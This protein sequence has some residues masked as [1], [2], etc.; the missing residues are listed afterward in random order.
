VEQG[1]EGNRGL[2]AM[3]M[4]VVL[5]AVGVSM[6]RLMQSPTYEASAEVLVDWQQG[7]ISGQTWGESGA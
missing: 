6:A 7:G 3:V 2:R 5:A 1:R 4:M